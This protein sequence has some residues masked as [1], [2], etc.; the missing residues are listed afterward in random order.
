MPDNGPHSLGGFKGKGPRKNVMR[1]QKPSAHKKGCAVT[2]LA[3]VGGA[4][5][6]LGGAGYG[7]V[8]LFN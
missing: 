4:V 7:I 2:A 3:M 5:A 6:A 8:Q 1:S